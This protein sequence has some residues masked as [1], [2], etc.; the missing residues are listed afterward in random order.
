VPVD[1]Y[2]FDESSFE[3]LDRA[4]VAWSDI[5]SALHGEHPRI[6]RPVGSDGL[7]LVVRTAGRGWL[8]AGFVEQP[9]RAWLLTDVRRV[10]DDESVALDRMFEG[11]AR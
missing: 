7:M 11:G 5:H 10:G 2:L 6:R 8:V 9:D 4:G 3:A 1:L